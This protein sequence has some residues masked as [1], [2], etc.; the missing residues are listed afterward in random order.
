MNQKLRL[1][2]DMRLQDMYSTIDIGAVMAGGERESL[3]RMHRLDIAAIGYCC[4][5]GLPHGRRC[6][7][8]KWFES[9]AGLR[10]DMEYE[11]RVYA[12]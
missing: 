9:I 12:R 10:A 3:D 11:R 2:Q 4:S 1:Q 8:Q 6:Q 7:C 5:C